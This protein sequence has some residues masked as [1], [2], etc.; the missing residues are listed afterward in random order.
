MSNVDSLS[1]FLSILKKQADTI[2]TQMDESSTFGVGSPE[3]VASFREGFL[4]KFLVRWF[5]L[6]F[7]IAKGTIIDSFGKRSSSIDCI[8]LNPNHPNNLY[9][10]NGNYSLIL[11][12]GVDSVV[13]LKP[14][15]QNKS[16]LIRGLEQIKSVKELQ[17]FNKTTLLGDASDLADFSLRIPSFIFTEK[18]KT[19]PVDTAREVQ[20]YYDTHKIPIDSQV[21]AI[22]INKVGVIMNNKI[23]SLCLK[24]AEGA[25]INDKG[26]SFEH[27]GEK[28]LARFLILLNQFP[29]AELKMSKP[30]I[31]RY[32]GTLGGVRITPVIAN[33]IA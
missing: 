8:I 10:E 11:C 19:N 7:K 4:K 1:C 13:E 2:S 12:D 14:D 28:T 6:P 20:E 26:I 18:C 31:L 3:A 17:R 9:E 29:G 24:T 33:S 30:I 32:F 21:D 15:I 16:E 25:P 5:P 22:I 23:S 27:W